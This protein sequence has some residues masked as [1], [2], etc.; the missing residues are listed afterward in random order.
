MLSAVENRI[1]GLSG[2]LR[3]FHVVDPKEMNVI[4]LYWVIDQD[5]TDD[6]VSKL[7][8]VSGIGWKGVMIT[9]YFSVNGREIG[10]GEKVEFP[11]YSLTILKDEKLF[12]RIKYTPGAPYV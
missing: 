4:N 1:L 7:A 11:Q 6:F 10:Q 9:K 12:G 2:K 8:D 3:E 5:T